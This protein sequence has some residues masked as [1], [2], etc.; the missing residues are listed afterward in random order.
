MD[1][2]WWS[3]GE[4]RWLT[5]V[6]EQMGVSEAEAVSI[7]L[8]SGLAPSA[9]RE[10]ETQIRWFVEQ[11]HLPDTWS[12]WSLGVTEKMVAKW[13]VM[14]GLPHEQLEVST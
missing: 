6:A 1:A 4:G 8:W 11:A 3:N 2:L 13:R 5:A 10:W 12:A 7:L 14:F 9:W